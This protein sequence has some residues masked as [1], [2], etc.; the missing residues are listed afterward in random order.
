MNKLQAMTYLYAKGPGER[1]VKDS[2]GYDCFILAN[3]NV[4]CG[5]IEYYG[6]TPNEPF[7]II[8]PQ[9]TN[10]QLASEVDNIWMNPPGRR[11][12]FQFI[13]DIMDQKIREA[14]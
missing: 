1:K 9:K 5:S 7:S 8:E 4:R 13:F 12:A 10:E 14:K 6:L 3:G 2:H 11:N